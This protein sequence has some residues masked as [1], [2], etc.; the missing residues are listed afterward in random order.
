MT[1]STK[2]L[3][4]GELRQIIDSHEKGYGMCVPV[5]CDYLM[6]KELLA[7]RGARGVPAGKFA[8]WGL[9][10][11]GRDGFGSWLKATPEADNSHAITKHGY[12]NVKLFTAPPAPAPAVQLCFHDAIDDME[13]VMAWI[14]KLPVP[15]DGATAKAGRLKNSIAAC[16]AAML[17]PV[18][19]GY[20]FD[21]LN[22]RAVAALRESVRNQWLKSEDFA[23]KIYWKNMHSIANE[24]IE[25]MAAAPTP[26]K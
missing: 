2:R 15:T 17:Q 20:T 3:T 7:V 25:A 8:G 13:N 9:Y 16:R 26:T 22:I 4:N 11:A 19:Q 6:A 10:H 1:K 14:M 21:G 12:V 5:N 24:I 23:D 18:S